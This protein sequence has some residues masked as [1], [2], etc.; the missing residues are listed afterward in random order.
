MQ[1][2]SLTEAKFLESVLLAEL[3]YAAHK[4]RKAPKACTS[5]SCDLLFRR[6]RMK[7]EEEKG[8]ESH[9]GS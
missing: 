4:G 7:P 2:L 8:G 5:A 9:N 6:L 1:V 3:D